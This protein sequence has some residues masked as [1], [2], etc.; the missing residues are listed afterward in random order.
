[1]RISDL[2]AE[3]RPAAHRQVVAKIRPLTEVGLSKDDRALRPEA[4]DER[5]VPTGDI[6]FQRK[7]AGGRR[8]IVGAFDIVLQKDRDALKR[9]ERL[10]GCAARIGRAG[11]LQRVRIYGDDALQPR[12]GPVDRLDPR[13]I[14]RRKR[15]GGDFAEAQRLRDLRKAFGDDASR[16]IIGLCPRRGRVCFCVI[17]GLR[18][19]AGGRHRQ[20]RNRCGDDH[21]RFHESLPISAWRKP[22]AGRRFRQRLLFGAH[23]GFNLAQMRG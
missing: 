2:S 12:P 1:M 23:F 7:R 14:V 15:F 19:A 16:A 3:R 13:D 17:A 5:R 22:K 11:V 20:C 10:S 21:W 18:C 8:H 4:G 6:V 9:P